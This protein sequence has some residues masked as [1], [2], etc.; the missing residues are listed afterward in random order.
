MYRRAKSPQLINY[1]PSI[2]TSLGIFFTFLSIYLGLKHLDLSSNVDNRTIEVLIKNISPA[3]ST[4]MLGIIGAIITSI[5]NRLII[6]Y[7]EKRDDDKLKKFTNQTPEPIHL[8]FTR[9]RCKI[10]CKSLKLWK[11]YTETLLS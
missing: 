7:S 2:W 9:M 4:S 3:F 1:I 8:K 10:F 6:A 11:V 5:I